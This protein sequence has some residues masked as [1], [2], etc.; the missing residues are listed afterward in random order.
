MPKQSCTSSYRFFIG[1]F[2]LKIVRRHARCAS[3][4]ATSSAMR[5]G[6][7]TMSH[8]SQSTARG[9]RKRKPSV[10][11]CSTIPDSIKAASIGP[12]SIA[13]VRIERCTSCQ[14]QPPGAAPRSTA[15][16]PGFSQRA[17]SSSSSK[18][19][20]A[21]SSFSVERLGAPR[22]NLRRGIP[23][24][25]GA[26][27]SMPAHAT[28]A[29]SGAIRQ[30]CSRV[31]EVRSSH[32]FFFS[33]VTSAA[34]SARH[35]GA[36]SRPASLSGASIHA[37]HQRRASRSMIGSSAA[38]RSLRSMRSAR[39][40]TRKSCRAKMSSRQAPAFPNGLGAPSGITNSTNPLPRSARAKPPLSAEAAYAASSCAHSPSKP[41]RQ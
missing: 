27:S 31:R 32:C 39:P 8:T 15:V 37:S 41:G 28:I 34:L 40:S 19:R 35:N 22:G 6:C 10:R 3:Q 17:R 7:S 38:S 26:A 30:T 16:M 2:R 23:P 9:G 36:S 11:R 33:A 25:Q 24:G 29:V 4:P 13:I 5:R 14:V 12:L 1:S 21:S 18:T 20:N